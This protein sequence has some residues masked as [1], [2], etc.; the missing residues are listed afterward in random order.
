MTTLKRCLNKK[1][2]Y[3]IYLYIYIYI[4]QMD[5]KYLKYKS[6]YLA[7]KKKFRQLGGAGFRITVDA[8][9]KLEIVKDAELSALFGTGLKTAIP[10]DSPASAKLLGL[11]MSNPTWTMRSV[12]RPVSREGFVWE[13]QTNYTLEAPR[14]AAAAEPA[15]TPAGAAAAAAPALIPGAAARLPPGTE[16][17]LVTPPEFEAFATATLADG[18]LDL[19]PMPAATPAAILARRY[20]LDSEYTPT[21]CAGQAMHTIFDTGNASHTICAR[22]KVI[23]L[24]LM[25]KPKM[26][27]K[28]SILSYNELAHFTGLPKVAPLPTATASRQTG[29]ATFK[30]SAAATLQAAEAVEF[31][32]RTL[33]EFT[34]LLDAALPRLMVHPIG[35]ILLGAAGAALPAANLYKMCGIRG[36]SGIGGGSTVCFEETYVPVEVPVVA[37]GGA[38]RPPL[39]LL[40]KAD[41]SDLPGALDLLVSLEDIRKL[42]LH[43]AKLD[44]SEESHRK[45]DELLKLEEEVAE[46]EPRLQI[47][48][49]AN[50]NAGSSEEQ[51]QSAEKIRE[52]DARL[53]VVDARIRVLREHNIPVTE[54]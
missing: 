43:G 8:T 11:Y 54:L 7:L 33:R 34:G 51:R 23:A 42:S 46:L 3:K 41:V 39:K 35:P 27:S 2:I 24:Q 40:F 18:Y 47:Y 21:T 48:R 50:I 5:Q 1:L 38:P 20:Q 49:F 29:V 30:S 17:R 26:A 14:A 44:F 45:R 22:R 6:K 19:R 4:Y 53:R 25:V 28:S 16:L 12:G 31:A 15:P 37:A 13:D 32:P 36:V 9:V 10:L 52:I